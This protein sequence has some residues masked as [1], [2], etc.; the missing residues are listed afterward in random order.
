MTVS[1]TRKKEAEVPW[2]V[3]VNTFHDHWK[4]QSIAALRSLLEDHGQ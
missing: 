4:K 3:A 1:A 2:T